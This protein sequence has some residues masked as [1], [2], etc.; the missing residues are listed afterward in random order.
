MSE[1]KEKELLE[2][3]DGMCLFLANH[4]W[5]ERDE[6]AVAIREMIKGHAEQEEIEVRYIDII[7]DLY[8]RLEKK[9]PEVTKLW[10]K[11]MAWDIW[12]KNFDA[13][14]ETYSLGTLGEFI[15]KK[16]TEADVEV[17]GK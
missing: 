12:N 9:K 4:Q 8:D 17:V 10:I 1:L 13:R 7:L 3:F 5:T 16:F 2:Y 11:K 6:R 15:K 14:V